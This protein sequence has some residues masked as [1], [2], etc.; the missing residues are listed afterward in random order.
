MS[1]KNYQ[2]EFIESNRILREIQKLLREV[3]EE[4]CNNME[5]TNRKLIQAED[6]AHFACMEQHRIIHPECYS[7]PVEKCKDVTD[8][9]YGANGTSITYVMKDG[10]E[11]VIDCSYSSSIAPQLGWQL[12]IP[13]VLSLAI[14]ELKEEIQELKRQ[15]VD[16]RKYL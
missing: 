9:R 10:K 15:R 7:T 16:P 6:M 3:I 5:R 2:D 1:E 8:V 13:F 12:F 14:K 4:D 11:E